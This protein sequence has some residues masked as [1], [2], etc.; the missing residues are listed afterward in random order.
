[1]ISIDAFRKNVT[2]T[3]DEHKREV[4][5]KESDLSCAQMS[6]DIERGWLLVFGAG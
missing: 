4:I 3:E 2:G 1:V 6:R 5:Y